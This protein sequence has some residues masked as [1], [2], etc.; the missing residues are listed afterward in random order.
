[1]YDC[2][3]L[4]A[5][6]HS[7]ESFSIS[8]FYS[9]ENFTVTQT[10]YN[11][12]SILVVP[13]D[14]YFLYTLVMAEWKQ[15]KMKG[16]SDMNRRILSVLS[17]LI[18]C[19]FVLAAC[20]SIQ[21]EAVA[22]K[23]LTAENADATLTTATTS[24]ATE[25]T[26]SATTN[27]AITTTPKQIATTAK[28]TAKTTVKPKTA[29]NKAAPATT[30]KITST[31]KKADSSKANI[32]VTAAR[33]ALGVKYV[34]LGNTMSGFDCSGLTLYCYNKAGITL[35]HQS[36]QQSGLGKYVSKA[37]LQPG[38]LIFFDT[39]GGNDGINHVGIYT[40]NGKFI[41]AL[42]GAGKVTEASLSNS[43]WVNAYMTAR[44]IL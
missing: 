44:R 4:S 6:F 35:P 13:Q 21:K 42:S 28:K 37:N 39:N 41:S 33:S 15:R 27:Q 31:A 7:I 2:Y 18:I 16:S 36:A 12:V 32:V 5:K 38:D 3:H 8:S 26:E 10:N 25:A 22:P 30:K 20:S 23:V 43:Y 11:S 9:R 1:M 14:E 40:G 29:S 34:F 17:V 24:K 19:T